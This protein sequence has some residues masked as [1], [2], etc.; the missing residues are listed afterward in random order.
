MST[1]PKALKGRKASEVFKEYAEPYLEMCIQGAAMRPSLKEIEV[2]LKIPWLIWNATVLK[3]RSGQIIDFW[4]SIRLLLKG[5]PIEIKKIIDL[6]QER[7]QTL[8]KQYDYLL[9]E[10]KLTFDERA[11]EIKLQVESRVM[12]K[13]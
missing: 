5:Q 11:K 3:N 13:Q 9:G 12:P 8:F 1:L 10:Y 4:A 7:K 6:M 2:M